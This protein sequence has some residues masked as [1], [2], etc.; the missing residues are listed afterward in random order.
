MRYSIQ[1]LAVLLVLPMLSGSAE[2]ATFDVSGFGT[3]GFTVTDTDD[4][5]Y[6]RGG[7]IVGAERRGNAGVDSLAGLQPTVHL[8]DRISGTAQL[9]L[10][11]RYDPDFTL[12]V[13]MAF[14]KAELT[15]A[16]AVRVG[17]LP[18][19]VFMV[20]DF[21][22]VGYANTWL[23]PPLEVY[24]QVALDSVDGADMLYS[25]SSGGL[26]YTA[27][28]FYGATSYVSGGNTIK[29]K[30][31]IGLNA[32]ATFGPLTLRA[33]RVMNE[34]TL[35]APGATQLIAGVRAAGFAA[36]ADQLDVTNKAA[37]FTGYGASLDWRNVIAQ[38]EYTRVFVNGFPAETSGRY[39]LVGYRIAKFTPYA[40]HSRRSQLSE[41]SN[42]VI[43]RVGPLIPLA[44]GVNA[45][46][47]APEQ[48][49]TA[50][51]LRWD[52]A[53]S[54]ALKAQY[55]YVEPVGPGLF[56]NVQSDFKGPVNVFGLAV[57]VVF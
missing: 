10:R 20:S 28:G 22:Q 23:R 19:P 6:I 2:A 4:A 25:G 17:R 3:A 43:P 44:L 27:Q 40:I 41:R 5:E 51:G 14:I 30:R 24:G 15:K 54:V 42:N 11:R 9:L 48:K 56:A 16:L 21:R 57:D 33:G 38:A 46:I 53:D 7:Q 8:S 45:I 32:S 12:D 39:G 49:S 37:S 47:S 31:F 13:P 35:D 18:L 29:V 52:V 50:L 34:V 1:R 36:L 26:S 55:D